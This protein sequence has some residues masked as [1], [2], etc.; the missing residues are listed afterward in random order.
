MLIASQQS[1]QYPFL[2][3]HNP[4]SFSPHCSS[5]LMSVIIWPFIYFW[6]L[7][8]L[9]S[10]VVSAKRIC[11]KIQ[12]Y[13]RNSFWVFLMYHD[14]VYVIFGWAWSLEWVLLQTWLNAYI[15]T[16]R[17]LVMTEYNKGLCYDAVSIS[18]YTSKWTCDP[19]REAGQQTHNDRCTISEQWRSHLH[20]FR[21][22]K[23]YCKPSEFA[24]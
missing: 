8:Q 3:L 21:S 12:G 19:C 13:D 9:G 5:I 6:F 2:W 10:V 1:V 16:V 22:V 15:D 24:D 4:Q 7:I 11:V 14:C 23:T 18:C 17:T 20:C